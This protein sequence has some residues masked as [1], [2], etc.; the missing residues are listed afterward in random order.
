MVTPLPRGYSKVPKLVPPIC[1]HCDSHSAIGRAQ[2][3][4]IIVSLGIFIINT[5][6]LDNYSQLGLSMWTM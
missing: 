6:P 4:I 5:I 3:N 2:S 1:I